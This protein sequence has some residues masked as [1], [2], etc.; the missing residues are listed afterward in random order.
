LGIDIF[1]V[2][3]YLFHIALVQVLESTIHN[4]EPWR[5]EKI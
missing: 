3:M 4:T 1:S 2:L 5:K